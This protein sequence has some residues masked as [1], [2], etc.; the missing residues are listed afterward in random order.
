MDN[1]LQALG[2]T[3]VTPAAIATLSAATVGLFVACGLTLI[4]AARAA[5]KP[6]QDDRSASHATSA[7]WLM[8]LGVVVFASKLAVMRDTPVLSP[9]WDL[10]D[11]LGLDVYIPWEEGRLKWAQMFAFHNEHRIFFSRLFALDAL[12]LNGQWDPR[13]GQ[14]LDA[15]VHALTLVVIAAIFWVSGGRRHLPLLVLVCGLM[16]VPAFAWETTLAGLQSQFYFFVLFSILALWLVPSY[17]PGTLPWL[18]GWMS[19]MAA[20]FTSAGGLLTTP[21]ILVMVCS[22][23]LAHSR[24]RWRTALNLLV[25]AAVLATGWVT[26]SPSLARHEALKAQS[27]ADFLGALTANLTWPWASP[28][29]GSVMW[30]PLAFLLASAVRRRFRTTA[31]ERLVLGLSVWI[32]LNAAAIAYGRGAGAPAPAGRYMDFLALGLVANAVAVMCLADRS[33]S[34]SGQRLAYSF[35]GLWIVIAVAGIERLS[36]RTSTDLAQWRHRFAAHTVHLR[37]FVAEGNR[38]VFTAL[39]PLEDL[40]FPA[41][42]FLISLLET[43]ALRQILSPALREPLRIEPA[44][45]DA[46]FSLED[47]DDENPSDALSRVWSARIDG[48]S[49]TPSQFS[50]HSLDCRRGT[51]LRFQIYGAVPGERR[52]RLRGVSTGKE[53]LI[54]PGRPARDGWSTLIVPCPDEPFVVLATNMPAESRFAFREPVEIGWGSLMA[55]TADRSLGN[56]ADGRDH[57]HHG[58]RGVVRTRIVPAKRPSVVEGGAIGCERQRTILS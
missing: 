51:G 37:R 50:S 32:L 20:L 21:A 54:Q 47:S 56:T 58:C 49:A 41:A 45:A 28:F 25:G 12:I 52:L 4:G 31:T 48:R 34:Y 39:R 27:A 22:R 26:R 11:G 6:G 36:S 43:P 14:V 9:Y 30:V 19:A 8:A 35:L 13:L 10:W 42:D 57:A 23:Y 33:T 5:T 16:G 2:A 17:G 38:T 44:V 3:L 29:L 7:L 40:P 1:P 18:L 15:G 55:E 46:G 53:V 24:E